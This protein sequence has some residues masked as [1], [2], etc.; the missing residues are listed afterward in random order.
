MHI[1]R[2]QSGEF[3]NGSHIVFALIIVICVVNY[4]KCV[5]SILC[6]YGLHV[7]AFR[8]ITKFVIVIDTSNVPATESTGLVMLHL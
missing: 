8:V 2:S 1:S 3:P 4:L 5:Y 7:I 6:V